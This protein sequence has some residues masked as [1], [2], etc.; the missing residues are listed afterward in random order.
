M[1]LHH[2]QSLLGW[3]THSTAPSAPRAAR[4]L[5]QLATRVQLAATVLLAIAATGRVDAAEQPPALELA[6]DAAGQFRSDPGADLRSRLG[7]GTFDQRQRA[8]WDLWRDRGQREAVAAAVRDP[9]PEVASRAQ[10]ILDRWRR[11]ILADTPAELARQLESVSHSDSLQRLL[12]LG[13]FSSARVA[14]EEATEASDQATLTRAQAVIERAFVFYIRSAD[15][16]G[17]LQEFAELVNRLATT[18]EMIICR[19]QLWE[20][21]GSPRPAHLDQPAS[22]LAALAPL[23]RQR[24][25]VIALA[26][27]NRLDEAAELARTAD[28]PE[29]LRVCQLL[30]SDWEGLAQSQLA[31][32]A[33]VAEGTAESDRHWAYILVAAARSG[34]QELRSRAVAALSKRASDVEAESANDPFVRLRWQVLAMHGEIDAA[35]EILASTQPLVAAELLAQ[36][37][38]LG[39]AMAMVGFTPAEIDTQL[40]NWIAAARA[41]T[42]QW[43]ATQFRDI[44]APVEELTT[45][46]RLLFL[47]GRRDA[48][49]ELLAGVAAKTADEGEMPGLA[50]ARAMVLQTLVRLNRS[51]WML[52]MVLEESTTSLSGT[53]RHFLARALDVQP[54]TL[55]ALTLALG[56]LV[57]GSGSQALQAAVD[58]L[59]GE[60]PA[61]FDPQKDYQRLFDLLAN[62]APVAS[63]RGD[64]FAAA[65]ETPRL[66]LEI[67]ELF[68]M[69]GQAELARGSLIHLVSRGES[70][71]LLE[72]AESELKAG[73]VQSA[74][75]VFAAA[76]QRIDQQRQDPARLNRAE[77]DALTAM[78]AILG[79]AIAAARL[80]DREGAEELWQLIDLMTCSPSAKLRDL[81][82]AHLLDEGFHQ[83][84]EPIFRTLVPWV[85]FGSDEGVEFYTVA[86]NFNRAIDETHPARAAEVYDLAIAGTI[87][88]TIFYPA[89]YV[90]LPAYVHRKSILAALPSGD[91]ATVQRHIDAIMRLNTIDIDFGENVLKQLRQAGLNELADQTIERIYQAGDTHLER[92]PLDIVTANNLAWIL[93]LSDH[94]L[95]DALRFSRRAVYLAPDSTVY[96]DTLA[97]V[98][99]RL[100][101]VDEAVAIA[102]ACLL[103]QPGE[104]HVHEQLRRFQTA[105]TE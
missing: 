36:A 88:S 42:A 95:D 62:S 74:R 93:A 53:G 61:G 33:Q 21:L 75:N 18:A 46:S 64:L 54:E 45:K 84:A 13:L 97:E 47:A 87:E 68:A 102:K 77:D 22:Q 66:N 40:A 2:L 79:E 94:R 14:I 29:L 12:D 103:D 90:S 73:H 89:A 57:P 72:L 78:K 63:G 8:M 30:R 76:W 3:T 20:R 41:A 5:S 7:S 80:G 37:G 98:L 34:D 28:D 100:G 60:V 81:F 4:R 82:G 104:W 92:F 51:D 85:A 56:Q 24:I 58:L 44:P 59:G 48:A 96:R 10:W 27:D 32:V 50:L 67:A 86:R 17:Q 1:P 105:K 70:E 101:R 55:D 91:V 65:R 15:Q 39:D 16:Q 35:A 9:D 25:E 99:F 31:A 11:G 71:A 52:E 26:V 43:S 49:W 6:Q 83:Q 19:N 38:R 23:D 69:H